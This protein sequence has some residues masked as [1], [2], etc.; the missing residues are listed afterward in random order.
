MCSKRR[1]YHVYTG[2]YKGFKITVASHGVGSSGANVIFMELIE[3]GATVLVRA[4]TCGSLG[5]RPTGSH[6]IATSC[7]RN[8]GF[9]V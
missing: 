1:E 5:P 9:V 4:G 3:A 7:V 8:D 2:F 6:I